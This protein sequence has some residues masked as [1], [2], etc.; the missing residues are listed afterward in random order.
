MH[1]TDSPSQQAQTTC[2]SCHDSPS[3]QMLLAIRQFND[4][5]WYACHET[6]ETLWLKETGEVRDFY[7]GIIQIAIALHHW[8]NGN[9]NGAIKLLEGG[10]GYLKRVVSPCLWVDVAALLE[11]SAAMQAR[12]QK[13][14]VAADREPLVS[15]CIPRIITVSV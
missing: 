10:C 2:R 5:Q 15:A 7:Q 11:Q 6:L 8:R 9:I 4:G 3:A 12:L 13:P 14:D 1:V